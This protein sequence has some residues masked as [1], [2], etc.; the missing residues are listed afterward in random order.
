MFQ[1]EADP[2]TVG[3]YFKTRD[4]KILTKKRPENK[5]RYRNLMFNE[6]VI[7]GKTFSNRIEMKRIRK[8]NR[9]HREIKERKKK[10]KMIEVINPY[11][12]FEVPPRQGRDHASTQT[13][14]YKEVLQRDNNYQS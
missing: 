7:R 8:D 13:Y 3:P 5:F 9:T 1:F 10:A 6:H 14:I 12:I 4:K 2:K 11:E